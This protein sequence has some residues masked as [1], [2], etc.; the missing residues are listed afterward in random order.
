MKAKLVLCLMIL[1]IC[2]CSFQDSVAKKINDRHYRFKIMVPDQMMEVEDSVYLLNGRLYYDTTSGIIL[3]ISARES[4]FKSVKDY[5]D[6]SKEEL[7]KQLQYN[8]GDTTLRLTSCSKSIYYP[9]KTTILHFQVS[10]LP[11]GYNSYVIYFVHH[12]DKD[13][14]ISFTYKKET[15]QKSMGYIDS[16]MQT[17]KLKQW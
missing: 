13:I 4:K 12:R 2:I 16:V 15:A 5:L 10:N 1:L 14:Q 11:F 8:Y 6:C 3:I 9:K 7:E 17:L